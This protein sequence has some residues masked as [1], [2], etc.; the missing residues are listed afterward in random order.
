MAPKKDPAKKEEDDGNQL[1]L[2]I[3]KEL[4]EKEL[5]ISCLKS[6]LGR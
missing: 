3:E 4:V 1:M 2:N 6:K 5:V